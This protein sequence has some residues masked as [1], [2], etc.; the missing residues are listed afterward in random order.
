MTLNQ[1]TESGHIIP[2]SWTGTARRAA[3]G[4]VGT[5]IGAAVFVAQNGRGW[6]H[7]VGISDDSRSRPKARLRS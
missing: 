2:G 4:G 6:P 1:A 5:I 3:A 7:A